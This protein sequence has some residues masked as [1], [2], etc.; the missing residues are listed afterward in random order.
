M[1]KKLLAKKIL[2]KKLLVRKSPLK[3][4]PKV[5][6]HLRKEKERKKQMPVTNSLTN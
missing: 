3:K 5:I 1:K 6:K 2:L 4:Q